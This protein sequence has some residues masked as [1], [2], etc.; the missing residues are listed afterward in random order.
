MPWSGDSDAGLHAEEQYSGAPNPEAM[1]DEDELGI[2]RLVGR[3]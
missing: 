1:L 2:L 3:E